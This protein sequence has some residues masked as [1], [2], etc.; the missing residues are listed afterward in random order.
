[1]YTLSVL[2]R[3]YDSLCVYRQGVWRD[4]E[5]E[6][7]GCAA[8]SMAEPVPVCWRVRCRTRTRV[9]KADMCRCVH[10]PKPWQ[11][12]FKMAKVLQMA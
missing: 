11:W 9:C 1:M 10:K 5:W 12:S 4:W 6:K 7:P 3:S 8:S 2:W